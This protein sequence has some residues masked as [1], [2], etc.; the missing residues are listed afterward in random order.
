[1]LNIATLMI[2]NAKASN[3]PAQFQE[4]AMW[5]RKLTLADAAL[6]EPYFLLGT[7][8]EHG[9]GTERNLKCAY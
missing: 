9:L 8:Q 3:T 2:S 4:S 6:A 5:L 1:M 7:L